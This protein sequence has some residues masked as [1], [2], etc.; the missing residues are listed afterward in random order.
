MLIFE[1]KLSRLILI[2]VHKSSFHFIINS[3]EIIDFWFQAKSSI[4]DFIN[5][6]FEKIIFSDKVSHV[7]VQLVEIQVQVHF[8]E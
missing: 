4:F 1:S 3:W 7:S 6:F 5:A 2:Q 8:K